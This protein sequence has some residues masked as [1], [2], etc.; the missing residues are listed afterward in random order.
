MV[1]SYIREFHFE[2]IERL[3]EAAGFPT[4]S[5]EDE[6]IVENYK[7]SSDGTR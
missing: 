5:K 7:A 3:M 6:K 2:A 1:R 4:C